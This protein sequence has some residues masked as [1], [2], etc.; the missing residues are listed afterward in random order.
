MILVVRYVAAEALWFEILLL[1]T[2]NIVFVLYDI[3]ITR[4]M[5][6]YVLVWR[7]RLRIKF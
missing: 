5:R 4:L 2:A 1:V 7:Q 6:A 3:A